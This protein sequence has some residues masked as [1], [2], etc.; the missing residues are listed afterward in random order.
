MGHIFNHEELGLSH[1][2]GAINYTN[3]F[4]PRRGEK[5]CEILGKDASMRGPVWHNFRGADISNTNIAKIDGLCGDL[6]EKARGRLASNRGGIPEEECEA[7]T[8]LV[9]YWLYEKHH[10]TILE[11]LRNGEATV[12][13]PR[14]REFVEEYRER[15]RY[16]P[17]E[18]MDDYAPA[19]TFGIY[20][21]ICRA[22]Y[23][24]YYYIA[25]G[26]MEAAALR[27]S[28]WESIFTHDIFRYHR[29][30]FNQMNNIATLITGE[31]GTGKELV[32][33]AIAFSQ[34][35]PVDE[36]HGRLVQDVVSCLKPLQL[37]AMSQ[38]IIE[39]EL[40]GHIKGAFT[41]AV[42]DHAGYFETCTPHDT[43]FLDEIGDTS[44]EMQIKLLRVLQSR[45]FHR[46]GDTVPREF[47]G[48]LIAATNRDLAKAT[49]EGAF[50]ADVYYR[51]CADTIET[52]P[53]RRM[54]NG[55]SDELLQF[56][57]VLARRILP[58]GREASDFADEA[59]EWIRDNLGLDYSWPGNVRELEQ[60]LRNL[61]IR[62][63]YTPRDILAPGVVETP[64]QAR[65][66]LFRESTLTA[67]QAM[68]EY[69]RA[70][71]EREGENLAKT[72]IITGVDRRTVKKYLSAGR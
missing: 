7:Y 44:L 53:L 27:A 64:S 47:H 38:N 57:H 45:R 40:F 32:A 25:G 59:H 63:T 61:L 12:E 9:L 49:R 52:V 60:C 21:Q 33:R 6:L 68:G 31:S 65:M 67:E 19:K 39:S 13:L 70:I 29:L 26:S 37:S 43:I 1:A 51:L 36:R 41:G 14:Y 22:F 30:L 15:M 28:I 18:Y 71:Y 5:E 8:Q 24:I 54:L 3:P 69:M 16:L 72:A 50:R 56:V 2:I 20:H 23:Y 46:I 10:I 58:E 66:R 11:T 62:G 4:S 17:K 35:I 42:C 48:K 55:D 34:Y